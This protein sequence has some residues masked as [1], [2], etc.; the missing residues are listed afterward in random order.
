MGVL[1][2]RRVGFGIFLVWLLTLLYLWFPAIKGTKR[3]PWISQKGLKSSKIKLSP[4]LTNAVHVILASDENTIGGMIATM[5][6]IYSNTK[7]NV[8]FHLIVSEHSVDHVV[9][10]LTKTKLQLTNYE[11]RPFRKEWVKDKIKVHSGRKELSNPLNYARFYLPKLFPN[12]K[13]RVIYIDSDCIVQGDIHQL[14][15]M[16]LKP[17]HIAAFSEDCSGIS[18]RL[19]LLKNNYVEYIDFKNKH[20]QKLHLNPKACSFNTGLMVTELGLWKKNNITARLVYWMTLNTKEEVYGNEKGGG[21]SQPPMMIVFYQNYTH[22]DPEWHIRHLG[23]TAGTSYSKQVVQ[24]AKL[25]H[26]SGHFKPWNRLAQHSDIWDKYFL[27]D[28]T[29]KFKPIRR[30][31]TV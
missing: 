7:H 15:S 2:V 18:K 6:S 12:L 30:A 23:M 27:P 4:N 14:Y 26:W 28:P 16:K 25:L 20:I 5:N 17:G 9:V 3:W 11:V 21:G 1:T 8:M 24:H 31:T 13:K 22:I 29:H 10:W 19:T